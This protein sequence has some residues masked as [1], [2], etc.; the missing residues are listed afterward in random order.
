MSS[1]KTRAV[2]DLLNDPHK[3]K[4]LAMDVLCFLFRDVLMAKKIGP[5]AWSDRSERYFKRGA[6]RDPRRDR[7]NLNRQLSDNSFTW[8][9]FR[10]AVEFLD[11]VNAVF[12]VDVT[13]PDGKVTTHQQTIYPTNATS[14]HDTTLADFFQDMITSVNLSDEE[15]DRLLHEYVENPLSGIPNDDKATMTKERNARDRDFRAKRISWKV[16]RRALVFLQL[17]EVKYSL[18]LTWKRGVVTDHYIIPPTD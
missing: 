3:K 10:R 9:T 5:I 6:D 17:K 15:W 16:F 11:P 7:G 8:G 2:F 1:S 14:K 18:I 4:R 13:W 12:Q